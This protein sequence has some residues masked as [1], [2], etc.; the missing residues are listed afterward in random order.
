MALNSKTIY[1]IRTAP[2][3]LIS[4]HEKNRAMISQNISER[5]S[6]FKLFISSLEHLYHQFRDYYDEFLEILAETIIT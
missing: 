5:F 3:A 2:N 6:F 1:F 4:F